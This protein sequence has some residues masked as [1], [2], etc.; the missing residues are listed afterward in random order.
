MY[1]ALSIPLGWYPKPARGDKHKLDL[2]R[3]ERGIK[4][5]SGYRACWGSASLSMGIFAGCVQTLT[6]AHGP[7]LGQAGNQWLTH[8]IPAGSTDV[9]PSISLSHRHSTPNPLWQGNLEGYCNHL[10]QIFPTQL[11]TEE[12][13][14]GQRQQGRGWSG[15]ITKERKKQQTTF[16][17]RWGADKEVWSWLSWSSKTLQHVPLP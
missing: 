6:G 3:L 14:Q 10:T 12:S 1:L 11:R 16:P 9:K 2:G 13:E 8:Y 7:V 4:D 15:P 17:G 5:L